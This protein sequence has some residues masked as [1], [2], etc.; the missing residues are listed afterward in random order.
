MVLNFYFSYHYFWDEQLIATFF[1]LIYYLVGSKEFAL[2]SACIG[3]LIGL[4]SLIKPNALIIVI[5]VLFFYKKKFFLFYP[6]LI[7]SAVAFYFFLHNGFLQFIDNFILYNYYY[8]NYYLKNFPYLAAIKDNW[9]FLN[10]LVVIFIF[11]IHVINRKNINGKLLIFLLISASC[12]YPLIGV[13]RFAPFT[14]FLA[15]FI[16]YL[17][18]ITNKKLF[19]LIVLFLYLVS[20]SFQT[21]NK[22]QRIQKLQMPIE[23]SRSKKII[24][25]FK[26]N[27]LHSK[28]FYIMS[29]NVEIYY[30]LDKPSAVYFPLMYPSI[31]SYYKDF[32]ETYI[33]DI[34][35]NRTDLIVIPQPI[36]PNYR[37]AINLITFVKTNYNLSYE[38]SDFLIYTKK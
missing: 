31:S 14:S 10:F 20:F 7:W 26:D 22:V 29:N 8:Q 9:Y 19:F 18:T 37:L 15:I 2:K 16:S 12:F 24:A 36:D 4:A 11:T 38:D 21:N 32:Q 17:L 5:P 28:S 6:V 30:L 3:I 34:K 33:S 23:D 1:L 25:Y 35:K 13:D 27:N